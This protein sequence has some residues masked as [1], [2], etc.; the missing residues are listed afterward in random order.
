M[1]NAFE[2][3]VAIPVMAGKTEE[4]HANFEWSIFGLRIELGTFEY[5][6]KA[7]E[8]AGVDSKQ[9]IDSRVLTTLYQLH[10]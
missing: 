2:A 3:L 10:I 1:N 8:T 6:E 4:H 7:L 5:D 9:V